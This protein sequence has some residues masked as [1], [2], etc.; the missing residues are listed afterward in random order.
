MLSLPWCGGFLFL[1]SKSAIETP[2]TMAQKATFLPAAMIMTNTNVDD[3]F[4]VLFFILVCIVKKTHFSVDSVVLGTLTY[5]AI[6]NMRMYHYFYSLFAVSDIAAY[7]TISPAKAVIIMTLFG[8]GVGVGYVINKTVCAIGAIYTHITDG[9]KGVTSIVNFDGPEIYKVSALHVQPT[10]KL[11][12]VKKP[13]ADVYEGVDLKFRVLSVSNYGILAFGP[14]PVTL[15]GKSG[16]VLYNSNDAYI[17]GGINLTIGAVVSLLITAALN[18]SALDAFFIGI[19]CYSFIPFYYISFGDG[20][21]TKVNDVFFRYDDSSVQPCSVM[22][23]TQIL[24]MLP[25]A[26]AFTMKQNAF[27][28]AYYNSEY[29]T[30]V[31]ALMLCIYAAYYY[32]WLLVFVAY[33]ALLVVVNDPII[34]IGNLLNIGKYQPFLIVFIMPVILPNWKISAMVSAGCAF[35]VY[36]TNVHKYV[37]FAIYL[38]VYFKLLGLSL[39]SLAMVL[40]QN[41]GF[42]L[43]NYLWNRPLFSNFVSNVLFFTYY[44]YNYFAKIF[45]RKSGQL[46]NQEDRKSVV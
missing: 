42:D 25:T 14:P 3:Q 18:L 41:F 45:Q 20:A 30:I 23:Y 22:T 19:I 29:I 9:P 39:K 26:L 38:Y 27:D 13:T 12:K 10:F 7:L 1:V 36:Y 31:L 28:V 46:V 2:K 15:F 32:S 5:V 21:A 4:F 44:D 33:T 17:F 43:S 37:H 40:H 35:F 8:K 6:D 34:E 16:T 24:L 11:L